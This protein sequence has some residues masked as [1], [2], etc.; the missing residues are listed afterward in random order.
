MRCRED[1]EADNQQEP[2]LLRST[3]TTGLHHLSPYRGVVARVGG[4]WSNQYIGHRTCADGYVD[5]HDSRLEWPTHCEG[6]A[7]NNSMPTGR[8]GYSHALIVVYGA[9]LTTIDVNIHGRE[10][11]C[12]CRGPT[13]K[14]G[15]CCRGG[16]VLCDS[17]PRRIANQ[18]RH[19][20]EDKKMPTRGS[21]NHCS[22]RIKNALVPR[23]GRLANRAVTQQRTSGYSQPISSRRTTLA[24]TATPASLSLRQGI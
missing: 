15:P 21:R 1:F 8:E 2:R 18:K 7:P 19:C 20:S 17:K 13:D 16:L 5:W 14:D 6:K 12:H 9:D 24:I 10:C 11:T 3:A 22:P 4:G 23:V